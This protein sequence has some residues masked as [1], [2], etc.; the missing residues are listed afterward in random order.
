MIKE[1][2]EKIFDEKYN[3]P[4][5]G[6]KVFDDINKAVEIGLKY[7]LEPLCKDTNIPISMVISA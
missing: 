6:N 1:E 4:M 2:I 5:E 7:A 3:S